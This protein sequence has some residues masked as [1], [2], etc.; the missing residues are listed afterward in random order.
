[1]KNRKPTKEITL[2]NIKIGGN[3][4][5]AIQSMTNTKTSDLK[6]TLN[7]IKKLIKAG[8]EIIRVSVPDKDSLASLKAIKANIDIPLIADIHFKHELAIEALKNG[9]DCV[10]INPGNIGGIDKFKEVIRVAKEYNK[11]IR[12]GV[13][14]G[15]LEKELLEKYKKPCA[16]AIS[17]SA[18]GYVKFCE[19]LEFYNFKV[20]LKSSDPIETIEACERFSLACEYPQHIGITEAGPLFSGSIRSSIGLGILLNMGIGDTLRVSLSADPVYEVKAAYEILKALKLRDYGATIISCPTCARCNI[21]IEK[22]S[23]EVE[24]KLFYHKKPIKVAI[25]GCIVNGPGEA[26]EADIGIAGGIGEGLLFKNGKVV[27]KVCEDKLVETLIKEI[28]KN[29]D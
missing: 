6:S 12:I 18:Q 27:K 16:Q 28:N 3:N 23:K 24:E 13:N 15:S 7:Q 21:D 5:I 8:V 25:M 29:E 10:R 14:S 17:E 19:E 22:I 4:P 1:M 2:G 26:K 11:A 9:A 20:S